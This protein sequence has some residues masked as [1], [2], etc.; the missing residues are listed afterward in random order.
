MSYFLQ[1]WEGL[2]LP[3][4]ILFK[5]KNYTLFIYC[6]H[7]LILFFLFPII[8]KLPYNFLI[9]IISVVFLLLVSV[10]IGILVKSRCFRLWR[11]LN[12]GR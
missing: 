5:I 12:G 2:I 9:Y 7:S 1:L 3:P 10:G 6:S 11:I 8:K 4:P